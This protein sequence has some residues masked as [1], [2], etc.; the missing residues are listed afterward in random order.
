MRDELS[1]VS[2]I[3]NYLVKQPG[4]K[5][6]FQGIAEWWVMKEQI[7]QSLENISDAM[8]MLVSKGFIIVKEYHDQ[9][10]YYQLNE[11]KLPEIKVELEKFKK[12]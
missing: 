11:E 12:K 5:D 9:P 4:A 2:S 1:A 6:T 3:L 8:D 7:N 10:N